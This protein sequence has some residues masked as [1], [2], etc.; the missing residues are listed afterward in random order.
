MSKTINEVKKELIDFRDKQSKEREIPAYQIFTNSLITEL[1]NHRPQTISDLLKIK[2]IGKSK[3]NEF[4]EIILKICKSDTNT[5]NQYLVS[6]SNDNIYVVLLGRNPGIY[7]SWKETEHQVNGFSGALF[8]KCDS[9]LEAKYLLNDFSKNKEKEDKNLFEGLSNEQKEVLETVKNNQNVFITGPGGTGKSFL[10]KRIHTL[11]KNKGKRVT[12][13]AMTGCAAVL[14]DV[15]AKTFHSW[16]GIGRG[17]GSLNS[18]LKKVRRFKIIKEGWINTDVL[19]LDEVS[20][21]SY[22][23]LDVLNEIA[24]SIRMNKKLFGGMQVVF[25]GDFYQLPPVPEEGEE[26]SGKFCFMHPLWDEMFPNQILL[27]KIFRQQDKE[28]ISILNNIREGKITPKGLKILNSRIIKKEWN[29][30]KPTRLVPTKIQAYKM[31]SMEMNKLSGEI[32]LFK[33]KEVNIEKEGQS[34]LGSLE[35]KKYELDYLKKSV[36]IPEDLNL[37]IGSQV[38]CTVNIDLETDFALVNGSKGIIKG[39]DKED[40]F[41]IVEFQTGLIKKIKNHTWNSENFPSLGISQLPLILAWA[42]TIH[43]AQGASIDL[44][45]LDIGN[46][47]FECGQT[48]VALSRVKTLQGLYLTKFDYKKIKVNKWVN[49]FYKSFE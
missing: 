22:K 31:N 27:E 8:K 9:L 40:G 10:I 48:Y 14:L 49:E 38:M 1:V 11:L 6:K 41:P 32:K 24:K 34:F 42:V 19:I 33:M 25:C 30:I 28:Y 46:S 44:V 4:G 3:A 13:C 36:L 26:N 37:K 20:M 15:K 45:E 39:F 2:G 43:K 16:S 29:D 18:L 21:L 17:V 7:Y 35:Q 23:L 47:I 5:I 12:V